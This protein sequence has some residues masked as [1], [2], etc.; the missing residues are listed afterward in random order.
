[1][2]R[3]GVTPMPP[4]RNATRT[5]PSRSTNVPKGPSIC[6]SAPGS[7]ASNAFLNC[8]PVRRVVNSRNGS[9]G[10]L[11]WVKCLVSGPSP[12]GMVMTNHCPAVNS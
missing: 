5:T 1:M 7:R 12:D 8:E 3:T 9:V 2:L 6:T 4:V 11:E 10:E